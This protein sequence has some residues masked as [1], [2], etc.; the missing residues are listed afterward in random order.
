MVVFFIGSFFGAASRS[1]LSDSCY[2]KY[3][4]KKK[5]KNKNKQITYFSS[6]R[7]KTQNVSSKLA[8][9]KIVIIFDNIFASFYM[10]LQLFPILSNHFDI[11]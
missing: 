7:D 2:I 9:L 11:L 4:Y 8:A 3:I 1:I 5:K 6:C 10:E